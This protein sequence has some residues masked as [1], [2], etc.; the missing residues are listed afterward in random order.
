MYRLQTA[1][2]AQTKFSQ[3]SFC[4]LMFANKQCMMMS[5]SCK[6]QGCLK[7]ARENSHPW[8]S[9]SKHREEDK[10]CFLGPGRWFS[11]A[12][13]STWVQIPSAHEDTKH[14]TLASATAVAFWDRRQTKKNPRKPEGMQWRHQDTVSRQKARYLMSSIFRQAYM[15]YTH[16]KILHFLK[17]NFNLCVCLSTGNRDSVAAKFSHCILCFLDRLLSE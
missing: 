3:T 11:H 4:W 7:K 6:N 17:T 8:T 14:T 1:N 5:V 9:Y 13:M 15:L 12:S 10:T 2:A 16:T